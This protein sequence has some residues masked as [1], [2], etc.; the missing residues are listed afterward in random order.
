MAFLGVSTTYGN[1]APE[2]VIQ[3]VDHI[4]SKFDVLGASY[5]LE[6]MNLIKSELM[7]TIT[8]LQTQVNEQASLIQD[9]Q[10]F[11][12]ALQNPS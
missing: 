6:Q 8:T 5:S 4:D 10:N 1:V 12:I 3:N 11:V 7:T 2:D 9:L